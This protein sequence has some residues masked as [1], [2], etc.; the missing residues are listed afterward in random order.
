MQELVLTDKNVYPT[1]DV[2]FSHIKKSKA[3][4]HLS[5]RDAIE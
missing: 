4:I 5:Q 3:S 1:E 2:L